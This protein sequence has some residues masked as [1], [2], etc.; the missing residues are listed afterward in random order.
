L[1][2]EADR[3]IAIRDGTLCALHVNR[4]TGWRNPG[5]VAAG[6]VVRPHNQGG[7]DASVGP[8]RAMTDSA[9]LI[10]AK[11]ASDARLSGDGSY[12]DQCRCAFLL[13]RQENI[14]WRGEPLE[15]EWE[16]TPAARIVCLI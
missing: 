6:V 15:G 10:G 9:R 14:H 4:M 12:E 2:L 11:R 5:V 3:A 13:Y 16:S 8:T 1:Q 7:P